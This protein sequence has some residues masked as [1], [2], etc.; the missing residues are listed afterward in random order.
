[1]EVFG[2]IYLITNKLNGKKYVGQTNNLERRINQ[3]RHGD[4]YVDRAI[5]AHGWENFTVE[6]LK[7]CENSA[8]LDY[9]EKYFIK[10]R[11]TR[12]PNG[13]NLTDGGEGILG[14]KHKP[15]TIALLKKKHK[16]RKLTPEHCANI[17]AGLKGRKHTLEHRFKLA[18]SHRKDSPFKNLVAELDARHMTCAALAKF[19]DINSSTISSKMHGRIN[20][21][22][23][24]RVKLEEILELPADYLLQR[25]PCEEI[26]EQPAE[27][28]GSGSYKNLADEM[29]KQGVTL[30]QLCKA[31][32]LIEA[33]VY[34]KIRGTR[35]FTARDK[36]KLEEL[37]QKPIE[38]LL[39]RED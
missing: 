23:R 10:A 11:N 33:T 34:S 32:G 36:V 27:N 22:A 25:F 7:E 16:G 4:Q 5:R 15:E 9:W 38:Y 28:T 24:D 12:K 18:I 29:E 37:F 2:V 21:T 1:M 3:H 19:L 39:K 6:V 26:N 8:E 35:N 13:Y 20:F 17:A 31:L 14:H 30:H